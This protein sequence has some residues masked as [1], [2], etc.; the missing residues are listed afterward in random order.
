MESAQEVV[1]VP[2]LMGGWFDAHYYLQCALSHIYL[3]SHPNIPPP[4]S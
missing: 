4:F 3:Y 2:V 1:F